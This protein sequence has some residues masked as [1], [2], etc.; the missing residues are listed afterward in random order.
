VPNNQL[1]KEMDHRAKKY[2]EK[3]VA[4]QNSVDLAWSL[5]MT[6]EFK[7]LRRTIYKTE[8]EF[9]RFRHLVV[10]S[11]LATGKDRL[12]LFCLCVD[13]ERTGLFF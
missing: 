1:I 11:V 13:Q 12:F 4:E 2:H 7:E 9:R 6:D 5:L 10:N 3:S 8:R